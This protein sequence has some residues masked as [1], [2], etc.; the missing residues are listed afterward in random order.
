VRGV[1]C[2]EK[3]KPPTIVRILAERIVRLVPN[4][5]PLGNHEQ[6]VVTSDLRQPPI[7]NYVN[8]ELIFHQRIHGAARRVDPFTPAAEQ[9]VP[10]GI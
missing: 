2:A 7:R 8:A 1:L 9:L 3:Q 10:G 5:R 4:F 6:R